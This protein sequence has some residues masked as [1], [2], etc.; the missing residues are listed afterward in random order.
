MIS[1]HLCAW[2]SCAP[3]HFYLVIRFLFW[4]YIYKHENFWFRVVTKKNMRNLLVVLI[5]IDTMVPLHIEY[6]CH[7]DS[8]SMPQIMHVTLIH[9]AID[10][11]ENTDAFRP[12]ILEFA[13]CMVWNGFS[14]NNIIP[15]HISDLQI[16]FKHTKKSPCKLFF[17]GSNFRLRIGK[18]LYIYFLMYSLYRKWIGKHMR[19][20]TNAVNV[21]AHTYISSFMTNTR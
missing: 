7:L 20:G 5:C 6:F 16:K 17:S 10:S 12:K 9:N 18:L 19:N 3:L 14:G 21:V 2:N 11:I 15:D 4:F 1:V 13:K 8:H